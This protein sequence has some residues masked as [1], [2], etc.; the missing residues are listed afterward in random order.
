MGVEET[1]KTIRENINSFEYRNFTTYDKNI[2]QY[3]ERREDIC[4]R[5]EEVCPTVAITKDETNR[6][7]VFSQVD[8]HGCGGCI[9][10]CPSGA[11]DYSPTNKDSLYEMSLNFKNTHPLIIPQKM[12]LDN[13]NV[14]LKENILPFKIE[15]E[16]FFHEA[17]FLTLA[18]ISSSQ[19]IFYSDFLSK[20]TSDSINILNEIY[21]KKYGKDAILVAKDEKQLSAAI[22]KVDFI[23]ESYFNFNQ[24]G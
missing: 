23:A 4:G 1:L 17:T 21:Q 24:E 19:L 12:S 22:S 8:C 6:H 3:H 14:E 16:K 9:S 13:L 2:C 18:Q 20:G 10:I 7:L 15:G 5:C 11:L